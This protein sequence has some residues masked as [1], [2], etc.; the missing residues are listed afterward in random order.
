M[1]PTPLLVAC[2]GPRI[3][4]AAGHGRL[5]RGGLVG[6]AQVVEERRGSVGAVASATGGAVVLRLGLP[7]LRRHAVTPSRP[8]VLCR[9]GAPP[10]GDGR[11]WPYFVAPP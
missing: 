10:L 2:N 4:L 3:A 7:F 1:V 11:P 9:A 8:L 6:V 5:E